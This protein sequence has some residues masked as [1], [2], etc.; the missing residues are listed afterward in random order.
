MRTVELTRDFGTVRGL[1]GLCLQVPVGK[2]SGLLGP[3]GAGK[4]TT[5]RILLGLIEPTSGAV[6]VLGRDPMTEGTAVR[7]SSGALLERSGHYDR[8]T[9]EENL[10][11]YGRVRGLGR[12]ERRTRITELLERFDLAERREDL[13]GTLSR[14][15]RRKLGI[16]RALLHRPA[17]L[18][19]DEPT[20][21]LDPAAAHALRLLL[22]EL[23]SGEHT[24]VLLT[25]HDLIAAEHVCDHIAV[26][27]DGTLLAAGSLDELRTPRGGAALSIKGGAFTEEL[28]ARLQALPPVSTVSL[29]DGELRVDLRDATA[30]ASVVRSIVENGGEVETVVPRRTTLEGAYLRLIGAA[31]S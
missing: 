18:F 17:L 1:D 25:T 7:A 10:E 2:V 3:N 28:L 31:E 26:I 16:A 15:M 8:L 23:R 11:F 13:A 4:T 22:V 5:I 6:D 30:Q 9:V 19:L 21:G 27:K 29:R 14:G 12:E 24:T 20:A